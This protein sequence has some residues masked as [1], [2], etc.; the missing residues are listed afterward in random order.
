M[1]TKIIFIWIAVVIAII[2]GRCLDIYLESDVNERN[3]KK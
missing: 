3:D 2:L 1:I